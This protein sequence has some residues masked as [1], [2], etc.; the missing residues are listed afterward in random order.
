MTVDKG[1]AIPQPTLANRASSMPHHSIPQP[2]HQIASGSLTCQFSHHRQLHPQQGTG[3]FKNTTIR[4]A[5]M[6]PHSLQD[7]QC[8]RHQYNIPHSTA[9]K[10][11][12]RSSSIRG[13]DPISCTMFPPNSSRLHS[14]LTNLYNRTRPSGKQRQSKCSRTNSPVF[15][16][17][18]TFQVRKDRQIRQVRQSQRRVCSSMRPCHI[19]PTVLSDVSLFRQHTPLL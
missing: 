10:P 11:R 6:R 5:A 8:R 4:T 18:T 15:H 16:S 7:R 17:N 3:V 19:Q 12:G 1:R 2:V 9:R 13:M 14:H